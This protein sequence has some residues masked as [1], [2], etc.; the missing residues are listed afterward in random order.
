MQKDHLLSIPHTDWKSLFT[1]LGASSFRQDQV[2]KWIYHQLE[3][4]FK[5]MSNVPHELIEKLDEKYSVQTLSIE[6]SELSRDGTCKWLLNTSDSLSIECVL[7]PE[8]SRNTVCLSSQV[9]C[10]MGCKFCSTAKMGFLRNLSLGE[11][12]EQFLIIQKYLR[13]KDSGSISNIVFMGMGEPLMNASAVAAAS[14][15]FTDQKIGG[16]AKKRITVSTSGIPNEIVKWAEQNPSY[17]LAI[18]LNGTHNEM[19]SSLMPVNKSNSMEKLLE[20]VDKYIEITGGACY[21]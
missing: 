15:L 17:K 4:D 18:S 1:D 3:F 14:D 9:G 7:I 6:K 5:K 10:G 20:S 11:I 16:L 19:R 12:V 8:E 21:F 2:A 13:E